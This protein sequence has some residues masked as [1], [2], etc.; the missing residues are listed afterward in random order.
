[1]LSRQRIFDSLCEYVGRGRLGFELVDVCSETAEQEIDIAL[2][3]EEGALLR[4]L[5]P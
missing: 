5:V 3:V 4:S 1:M 2:E